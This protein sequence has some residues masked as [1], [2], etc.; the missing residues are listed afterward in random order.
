MQDLGAAAGGSIE[1]IIGPMFG[2]KTAEMVGRIRRAALAEQPAL[3]VKYRGDCRY[4]S[5]A[6]VATH[7]DMRQAS[8]DATD[9]VAAVRVVIADTLGE[10]GAVTE[11]VVGVDEGQFYPD[12]VEH[13]ER[14]AAEGRRVIVAALDGDF[15]RRP[16]G[17]VCALVPLCEAVVKRRGGCMGCR[18]RESAFSLRLSHSTD[19]VE[20]GAL[21][22]YRTV[23]RACYFAAHPA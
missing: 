8:T 7:A 15:A 3:I 18:R 19:L 6:T 20:I 12:L 22:S 1:L 4:E 9:S 13:C 5:G 16:F 14:W 10:V 17:Q 21:E 23:C 2:G 11:Q